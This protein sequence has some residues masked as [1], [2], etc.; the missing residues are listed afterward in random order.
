MH[1]ELLIILQ[2]HSKGNAPDSIDK[3]RYCGAPKKEVSRRC[4]F[5]LF[6]SI[7]YSKK[8]YPQYTYKLIVVDDHSDTDFIDYLKIKISSAS[9]KSELIHTTAHGLHPS[10][11]RCYELGK[12]RGKDLVY[13]AQDDYLYYE[14]AIYEMIGAY[15]KFKQLSGLNVCIFP[16]DDP[17]RYSLIQHNYKVLLGEKRHWKTSYYVASCFMMHH[18]TLVKEWKLFEAMGKGERGPEVEDR[19]INRLFINFNELPKREIDHVLFTPIPSLALHMGFETE[20]DPF[21]DWREL[22]DKFK[23]QEHYI[24]PETNKKILLNLG[25][26][27]VPLTKCGYIEGFED[28]YEVRVD[29]D[30][31]SNPDIFSDV[32]DLHMIVDN[33]VDAVYSSHCLE[34]L[35]FYDVPK[36]LKEWYR[37]LKPNGEIR[38]LVPDIS[39]A[40]KYIAEDK[41]FNVMYESEVGPIDALDFFYGHKQLTQFHPYMAHKTG[42]TKQSMTDLCIFMGYTHAVYSDGF[43]IIARIIKQ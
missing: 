22:W 36:C 30:E 23:Q 7:E 12:E 26:G 37:V 15:N 13:F 10:I 28:Y 6:N 20:K 41:P 25:S 8:H 29:L 14:T 32:K 5:S 1:Q 42:F 11:M 39:T 27:K 2:T 38:I 4:V 35:E 31:E 43:N 17:Y 18:N 16:Y 21:L 40:A 9:F 24:F 19:S 34:H 33:S 3:K